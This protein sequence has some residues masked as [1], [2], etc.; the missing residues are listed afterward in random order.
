MALRFKTLAVSAARAADD[1]KG[2]DIALRHLRP[3]S[4]TQYLLLVTAGSTAQL[5]ALEEHIQET[6]EEKGLWAVHHD[7]GRSDHWRVLDYGGLLVHLMRPEARSFYGLD[8]LY[9]DARAI[10]WKPNG[11][12]KTAKPK[13]KKKK[14]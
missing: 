12:T 4:L 6:L 8:R 7:G 3:A 1:K 14:T 13:S 11:K 2:E 5:E 10:D 9:H